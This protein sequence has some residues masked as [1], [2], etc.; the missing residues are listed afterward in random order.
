MTGFRSGRFRSGNSGGH[1]CGIEIPVWVPGE[2]KS[3]FWQA[4]LP[5]FHSPGMTGMDRIPP[6]SGRNTWRTV[7]NSLEHARRLSKRLADFRMGVLINIMSCHHTKSWKIYVT[8][9]WRFLL[10]IR[11]KT[12]LCIASIEFCL[13]DLT[14]SFDPFFFPS[15]RSEIF[16]FT[17]G[18]ED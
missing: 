9:R 15:S 1:S 13:N 10:V 11:S 7:K 3:Q 12:H 14:G 2:R 17:L 4:A 8:Y 18:V 6:D 5:K 16:E